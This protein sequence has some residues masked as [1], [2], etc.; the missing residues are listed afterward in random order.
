MSSEQIRVYLI[1]RD[2]SGPSER[3]RLVTCRLTCDYPTKEYHHYY[4]HNQR[5]P[6]FLKVTAYFL[7]NLDPNWKISIQ[8][9]K[10]LHKYCEKNDSL[11]YF[12][13]MS[14]LW[15]KNLLRV[16]GT[17]DNC[18]NRHN[19]RWCTFFKP[20]YLFPQRTQNLSIFL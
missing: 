1:N 17:P 18:H 4:P 9:G 14:Y 12:S 15:P 16:S 8:S 6:K 2:Y 20:A 11:E 7:L 5:H 10:K 3:V 19:R 13:K